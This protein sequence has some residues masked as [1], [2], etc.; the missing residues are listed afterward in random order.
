MYTRAY[1]KKQQ[2][3]VLLTSLVF[4]GVITMIGIVILS[5]GALQEKMAGNN[6]LLSI[7]S[8]AAQAAS[9][10]YIVDAGI[11]AN[12][13]FTDFA[14]AGGAP[15]G[16]SG[17]ILR[18]TWWATMISSTGTGSVQEPLVLNA[19]NAVSHCVDSN[20]VN[21]D[22]ADCSVSIQRSTNN[23]APIRAR[24]Q[25]Y[26]AGCHAAFCGAGMATSL[27][28]SGDAGPGCIKA[29]VEGAAWLD[30]DGD[31]KP[32]VG[33]GGEAIVYVDQWIR[34]RRPMHCEDVF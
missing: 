3:A 12:G 16:V 27:S 34:W 23:A 19:A 18:D 1:I 29:Y 14:N 24:T 5:T 33:T 4:L 20:G 21:V 25:A 10:A 28:N 17:N 26:F 11:V 6:H 15:L 13:S 7:T 9:D 2:G 22:G 8:N 32:T 31:K 30:R